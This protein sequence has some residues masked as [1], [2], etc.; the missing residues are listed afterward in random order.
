MIIL[1]AWRLRKLIPGAP[2][3][4][5]I[6]GAERDDERC[7]TAHRTTVDLWYLKDKIFNFTES[8]TYLQDL[9]VYPTVAV[10]RI[11]M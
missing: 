11:L 6:F 1:T 2:K 7:E 8:K 3:E 10:D 5:I 9:Y 4:D